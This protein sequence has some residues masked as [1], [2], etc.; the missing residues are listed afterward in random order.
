M[1]DAY[2]A[3]H[4]YDQSII[5]YKF[6]V[7]C[8][9][10]SAEYVLLVAAAHYARGQVKKTSEVYLN[11]KGFSANAWKGEKSAW[12]RTPIDYVQTVFDE[13]TS[14]A[15]VGGAFRLNAPFSIAALCN[16]QSLSAFCV[17]NGLEKKNIAT[18]MFNRIKTVLGTYEGIHWLD[19]LELGCGLGSAGAQFKSISNSLHCI[20]ASSRS[21]RFANMFATGYNS[22]S[23]SSY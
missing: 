1:G 16:L 8:D 17:L 5:N 22:I 12:H 19:T 18:M 14:L 23:V 6:A 13:F 2:Q 9:D 20:E 15:E 4:E 7:E 11:A 3:L 10:E 21:V